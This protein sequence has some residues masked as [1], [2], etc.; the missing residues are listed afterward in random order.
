ML[1]FAITYPAMVA[2]SAI[3]PE[4]E[5]KPAT[6]LAEL[7]G[8]SDA[9]QKLDADLKKVSFLSPRAW[10]IAELLGVTGLIERLI[11]LQ[12]NDRRL[13]GKVMSVE[14]L[15]LR[16]ELTEAIL[17]TML[18]VHDVIAKI[19]T[20]ISTYNQVQNLLEDKRDRAISYNAWANV[21][22]AGALNTGGAAGELVQS[23]EVP[24]EIAQVVGGGINMILGALA[25]RQQ[26]GGRHMTSG[27]PNML[28][29]IFGRPT[30]SQ[31][32]YPPLIWQYLNKIPAGSGVPDTR[33]QYVI[34]QWVNLHAIDNPATSRGKIQIERLTSTMPKQNVVTIDLLEDRK[35]LLADIRAQVSQMDSDLLELMNA[36][37]SL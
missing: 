19:D 15:S 8:I 23:N 9:G 31:T 14:C 4:R 2:A 25:L 26:N 11:V 32:E 30:E 17:T 29:Q 1:I 36:I 7:P 21:I 33:R 35:D 28:A 18:Q 12:A 24:G 27:H 3:L 37:R 13:H 10:D 20:E 6:N 5:E 34:N 16:Q 22:G